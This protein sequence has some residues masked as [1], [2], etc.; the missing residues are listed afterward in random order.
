MVTGG[1]HVMMITINNSKDLII[2][3]ICLWRKHNVLLF[4]HPYYV[5][6]TKDRGPT[7]EVVI[8]QQFL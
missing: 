7:H 6:K 2:H 3:T 4:K 1:T 5:V 8:A